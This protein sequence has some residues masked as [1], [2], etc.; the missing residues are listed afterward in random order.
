MISRKHA[1]ISYNLRIKNYK[2]K[3]RLIAQLPPLLSCS[4]QSSKCPSL[5]RLGL[6][7]PSLIPNTILNKDS[8]KN[9]LN[10]GRFGT[11]PSGHVVRM[12]SAKSSELPNHY[13]KIKFFLQNNSKRT[14][15]NNQNWEI[16][17]KSMIL[18]KRENFSEPMIEDKWWKRW[19]YEGFEKFFNPTRGCLWGL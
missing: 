13:S 11:R 3:N 14:Q 2:L 7:A 19:S 18:F 8:I 6:S 17:E 16:S 12:D 4:L 9:Q 5:I 15:D 1:N 10:L